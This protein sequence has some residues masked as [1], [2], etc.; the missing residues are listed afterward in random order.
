ML[1]GGSRWRQPAAIRQG[2]EPYCGGGV[3]CGGVVGC[4]VVVPVVPVPLPVV[5][6]PV[7]PDPVVPGVVWRLRVPLVEVDPVEPVESLLLAVPVPLVVLLPVVA[8]PPV[9][10]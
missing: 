1:S 7:L 2:H 10:A 6:L 5:P 8:L 9:P 4:G 3:D